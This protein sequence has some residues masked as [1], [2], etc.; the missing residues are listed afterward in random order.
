MVIR[1]N[2]LINKVINNE[3]SSIVY[4]KKIIDEIISIKNNDNIYQI[5]HLKILLIG[6]K[7]VGKTTLI[8]YMLNLDEKNINNKKFYQ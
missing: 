2:N 7:G 8:K 5:D 1:D 6:R 3:N 4:K